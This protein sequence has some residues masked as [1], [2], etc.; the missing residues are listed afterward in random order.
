MMSPTID[1]LADDYAGRV[2]I[3]TLN[4]D[5]NGGA[6]TPSPAPPCFQYG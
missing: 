2:T 4:V 3:G 5:E 1:A 6:G